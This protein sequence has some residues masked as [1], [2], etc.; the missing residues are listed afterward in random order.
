[1]CTCVYNVA[2]SAKMQPYSSTSC[3]SHKTGACTWQSPVLP[4]HRRGC[5]EGA[6]TRGPSF[7]SSRAPARHLTPCV[8]GRCAA[9]GREAPA[10]AASA[11]HAEAT[12][13]VVGLGTRSEVKQQLSSRIGSYL[14]SY[15]VCPLPA[16]T[17]HAVT[18]HPS[19]L[20]RGWE[21]LGTA[22]RNRNI[23]MRTG[24]HRGTWRHIPTP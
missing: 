19:E 18:S 1:M 22:E 16:Q 2:H 13:K 15:D 8:K 9:A 5:R 6:R 14:P 7:C 17:C 20:W 23:K 10:T 21:G 24:P 3:G 4:A 12:H 11:D